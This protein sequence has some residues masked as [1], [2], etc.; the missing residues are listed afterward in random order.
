M[1]RLKGRAALVTGAARG[2]GRATALALAEEGAR[3]I[4]ADIDG[5]ALRETQAGVSAR[6]ECLLA[7][8]VDV[9]N[10]ERMA[11]FAE[12]V[13][14]AVPCVDILIN[15]AGVYL[16]GSLLEISLDDWDWALSINLWGIIHTAHFFVPPMVKQGVH[17]HVVNVSSM[18]GYW[19][20]PG[21][22]GYLTAKFGV[23]GFSEALREDLRPYGIAVATVCRGIVRTDLVRNMRRRN[24]AGAASGLDHLQ[25]TYDRRNYGPEKVA[26]AIVRAILRN[27]KR[28]MVSPEAHVMYYMERFCPWLSRRIARSAT[29]RMLTQ[30]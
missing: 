11:A 9:A 23:F 21:V 25:K 2:I 26:R 28:V 10:R 15:N 3:L 16:T 14:Q 30:G 1:A 18:Y 20:A 27:R 8:T 24:V 7:E 29:K 22:I 17:G 4:L 6:S 19:P 13:H 12:S 5:A